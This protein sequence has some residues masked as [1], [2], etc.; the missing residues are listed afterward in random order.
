MVLIAQSVI[1]ILGIVF[2]IYIAVIEMFIG[3]WVDIVTTSL[4]MIKETVTN[5]LIKDLFWGIAK[6][7]F[8][9]ITGWLILVVTSLLA[10]LVGDY[11]E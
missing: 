6:V 7:I 1:W 4:T 3:G 8:S 11:L 2:A 5:G 10:T 9:S